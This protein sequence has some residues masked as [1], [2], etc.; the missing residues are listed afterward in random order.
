MKIGIKTFTPEIASDILANHNGQNIRKIRRSV[1]EKYARDM[2]S[3]A[4]KY[5]WDC[6]AF[7]KDGN[8]LNGQHRMQAI[9]MSGCTVDMLVIYD[10][11][12]VTGDIGMKRTAAEEIKGRGGSIS[13]FVSTS[14][15][16]G[17]VRSLYKFYFGI[18]NATTSEVEE[19]V[20][21]PRWK[22]CESICY[23]IKSHSKK[24]ISTAMVTT[25]LIGAF[26]ITDNETAVLK[27][28]EILKSGM[29]EGKGSAPVIAL[30]DYLT[31]VNNTHSAS[32]RRREIDDIRFV[33]SAFRAYLNGNVAK[34]LYKSSDIIYKPT[35]EMF[36]IEE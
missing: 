22:K 5:T 29:A 24:G 31:M 6:I 20:K 33:Q 17:V 7:D 18:R 15:G 26:I 12:C 32:T 9:V 11:E 3:G 35:I 36:K 2:A 25:A 13:D 30:R 16:T 21:L 10:A 19:F 23:A 4:W 27:F 8:L 1:A 34:R 14:F 28:I